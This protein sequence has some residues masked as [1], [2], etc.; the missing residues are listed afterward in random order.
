MAFIPVRSWCFINWPFALD[1]VVCCHVINWLCSSVYWLKVL[2][3]LH[4]LWF[5]IWTPVTY[6]HNSH[7]IRP[8]FN[9]ILTSW[10][11]L[12]CELFQVSDAIVAEAGTLWWF[13][14]IQCG[15]KS[16]SDLILNYEQNVLHRV[17]QQISRLAS[18]Y[19]TTDERLGMHSSEA[20]L[21]MVC[22][23]FL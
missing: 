9:L 3:H 14:E 20:L 19:V 13:T 23:H 17:L 6:S 15:S 16:F 22:C 7:H 1:T 12:F 21:P 4:T 18:F 10:C 5:K 11:L 8:I 2:L